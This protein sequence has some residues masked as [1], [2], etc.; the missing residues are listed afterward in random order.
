MVMCVFVITNIWWQRKCGHFMWVDDPLTRAEKL[1]LKKVEAENRKLTATVLTMT[2]QLR[3][4]NDNHGN[5]VDQIARDIDNEVRRFM[6]MCVM[7]VVYVVTMA[8]TI[9]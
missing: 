4:M 2:A 5:Y 6:L 8:T 1:S 7:V 3:Q 9:P